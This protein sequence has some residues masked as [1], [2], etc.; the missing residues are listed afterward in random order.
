[1]PNARGQGRKRTPTALYGI[2]GA[3]MRKG[4]PR[5]AVSGI[6]MPAG[7]TER[8]AAEWR[9]LAP[10]LVAKGVLTVWDVS[11]FVTY[12]DAVA[13]YENARRA[14]AEDGILTTGQKGNQVTNPAVRVQRDAAETMRRVGALF[15]LTPSDRAHLS[16]APAQATGLQ[17]FL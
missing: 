17:E 10:D 16:I 15:G 5:P 13:Q 3:R 2:D 9:R 12:C 7:L 11:L 14:V 8:A 6:E 4:E 1:M